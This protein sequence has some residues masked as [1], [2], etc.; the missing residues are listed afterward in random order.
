[1]GEQ[2]EDKEN[3]EQR[4]VVMGQQ[5]IETSGGANVGWEDDESLEEIDTPVKNQSLVDP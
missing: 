3:D 4:V 5:P 1:M 2:S